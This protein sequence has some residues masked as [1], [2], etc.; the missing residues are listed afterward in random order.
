MTAREDFIAWYCRE[1]GSRRVGR[2]LAGR[3]WDLSS[4]YGPWG[5]W[6]S[7]TVRNWWSELPFHTRAR[8]LDLDGGLKRWHRE[9]LMRGQGT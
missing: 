4:E 7:D 8:Y 9:E 1:A 2:R 5:S 3:C 6:R